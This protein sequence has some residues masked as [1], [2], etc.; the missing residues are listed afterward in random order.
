M[1]HSSVKWIDF[2]SPILGAQVKAK[3]ARGIAPG[4]GLQ[5]QAAPCL[6]RMGAL[7]VPTEASFTLSVPSYVIICVCKTS[8]QLS[9]G[10]AQLSLPLATQLE[11]SQ[12]VTCLVA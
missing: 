5:A 4:Q 6:Q 7:P 2:S 3:N 1:A 10:A 11:R 8:T 9:Q 12:V